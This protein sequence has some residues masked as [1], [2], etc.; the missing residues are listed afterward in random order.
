M[1][2][3]WQQDDINFLHKCKSEYVHSMFWWW[4]EIIAKQDRGS[5]YEFMLKNEA[6]N[7]PKYEA[8]NLS[9]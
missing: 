4:L 7:D 9:L 1:P 2:I 5:L 6:D 3:T 8:V